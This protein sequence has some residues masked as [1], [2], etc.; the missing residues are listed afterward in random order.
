V[1]V[2]I[3]C[4]TY[5]K[6]YEQSIGYGD[7]TFKWLGSCAEQFYSRYIPNGSIRAR[8]DFRGLSKRAQ[9]HA[10]EVVLENGEIPHP[11]SL[12]QDYVLDGDVLTV[13]L[14]DTL[15]VKEGGIPDLE[16]FAALSQ[17]NCVDS[18]MYVDD[19]AY[20]EDDREMM[21]GEENVGDLMSEVDAPNPQSKAK[22]EREAKA[23]ARFMEVVLDSQL[24]AESK[25]SRELEACWV[26]VLKL[27]PKLS[28]KDSDDMKRIFHHHFSILDALFRKYTQEE[29]FMMSRLKFKE[30]V[31]NAKIFSHQEE[32]EEVTMRVF[33]LVSKGET[34]INFTGFLVALIIT[35]QARLHNT[36]EAL[37]Y[38]RGAGASLEALIS[39]YLFPL[40]S[41]YRLRIRD[42]LY[43]PQPLKEIRDMYE[44]LFSLFE[45][46]AA[47]AGRDLTLSMPSQYFAELLRD[48]KIIVLAEDE[49]EPD[50]PKELARS[51]AEDI[52]ERC[53][54]GYIKGR[55]IIAEEERKP[56]DMP[57]PPE[58]DYVFPEFI[59]GIAR[60]TF[61]LLDE[62]DTVMFEEDHMLDGFRKALL[63]LEDPEPLEEP[64]SRSRRK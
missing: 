55:H 12:L 58:E 64:M 17:T 32:F 7:K 53:K 23:A 33:R 56:S 19:S 52:L 30:M 14:S 50:K 22:E 61:Y 26:D 51:I 37:S 11:M 31:D 20:I 24:L 5:K 10:F 8:D 46:Y 3:R 48:S 16:P 6:T 1:T 57:P 45:K 9:H 25:V 38:V 63:A 34:K 13:N 41:K 43:Q 4:G 15:K 59:E 21:F 36:F 47:K 54:S 60:A 27:M 2:E 42:L 40:A 49:D 62:E 35:A 39:K 18:P 29:S 28:A 44:Q